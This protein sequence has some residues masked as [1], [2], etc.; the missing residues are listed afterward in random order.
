MGTVQLSSLIHLFIMIKVLALFGLFTL[1]YGGFPICST[2]YDDQCWDEP[3]QQ[4]DYVQKPHTTTV[5]EQECNT[6]QVPKVETVPEERCEN[7]PEQKC[8]NRY[9]GV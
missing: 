1:S 6:I 3:R 8:H 7:V 9:G 5:Y 4:C 2:V